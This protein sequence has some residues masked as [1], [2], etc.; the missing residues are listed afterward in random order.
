ML[1]VLHQYIIYSQRQIGTDCL[2]TSCVDIEVGSFNLS[3]QST[4]AMQQAAGDAANSGLFTLYIIIAIVAVLLFIGGAF[5][6]CFF[7]IKE[8]RKN[9][10][11]VSP[12]NW[13]DLP[14]SSCCCCGRF[15]VHYFL[16]KERMKTDKRRAK[17]NV[18]LTR[19]KTRIIQV[20]PRTEQLTNNKLFFSKI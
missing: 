13:A 7:M 20:S 18:P 19:K 11:T 1:C 3:L 6:L 15:C 5:C 12:N 14:G 2:M 16:I 9:R 8:R 4:L 17:M 10:A